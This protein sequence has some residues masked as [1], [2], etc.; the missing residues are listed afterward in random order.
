MNSG[1]HLYFPLPGMCWD[2]INCNDEVFQDDPRLNDYNVKD[3]VDRAVGLSRGQNENYVGGDQM[4]TMGCELLRAEGDCGVCVVC[5]C[6]CVSCEPT[7]RVRRMQCSRWANAAC[8]AAA[9]PVLAVAEGT[10][11]AAAMAQRIAAS[12]YLLPPSLPSSLSRPFS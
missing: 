4:W 8:V 10:T 1:L 6:V 2:S 7:A 3:I 11:S 12:P 5:V 9:S